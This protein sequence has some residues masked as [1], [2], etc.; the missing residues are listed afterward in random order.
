[1]KVVVVGSGALG[2]Y[3][4]FTFASVGQDVVLVDVDPA[5]IKE[6]EEEGLSVT[7]TEGTKTLQIPITAKTDEVGPTDLVFFSV[8]SYASLAA[9][10]SL[11]PLMDK[12]TLVM[13]IQNGIGNV[14]KIASVVGEDKVIGG[15][16]AH[17]FEML[18][19]SHIRYVGGMGHAHIGKIDG[20]NT[21]RV[22]EVAELLRKGGVEIEVHD[23]IHDFIWFKLLVNTPINAVAAIT[24]LKNGELAESEEG[25][26]LMGLAAEE[27]FAVARAAG[28]NI[29]F[30]G[31]PVETCINGL[32]AAA[33]N[34]ASMLQDVANQRRTEIEAINGAIVEWGE[35]LG[36]PTP[37]NR[38]LA[39]LVKII[40]SRYLT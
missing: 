22:S 1:M 17:S 5:K 33:E 36:V 27:A 12:E 4:G 29:L 14:E 23:N 2:G 30:E 35:K 26:V 15:I 8:K 13:S 10:R 34:Q 16:T 9:A 19:P 38:L 3:F 20:N 25:R 21:P 31:D 18:S 6:I 28:V 32:R 11:P 7:S 24:R 39:G 37:V 40:Q